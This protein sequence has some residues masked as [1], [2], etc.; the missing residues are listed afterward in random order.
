MSIHL[1]S[2]APV[3]TDPPLEYP[4]PCAERS[5]TADLDAAITDWVLYGIQPGPATRDL[6]AAAAG[7]TRAQKA[8]TALRASLGIPEIA[9]EGEAWGARRDW[10]EA[11][12]EAG[13]GSPTAAALAQGFAQAL[14][15]VPRPRE[16]SQARPGDLGKGLPRSP[17]VV[18][19]AIVDVAVPA[20]P[21]CG[22]SG[23]Q[24][25]PE[26]PRLH[27]GQISARRLLAAVTP[28]H[29]SAA[30]PP[31]ALDLDEGGNGSASPA[32]LEVVLAAAPGLEA[33]HAFVLDAIQ[34][35]AT[36]IYWA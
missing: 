16:P 31:D 5:A 2:N 15:A 1:Y 4:C 35:G 17:A 18:A 10:V 12:I 32:A 14:P 24:T 34:R 22:G 3:G 6:L 28:L 19:G 8:A 9:Y 36:L 20:C 30:L 27:G 26:R 29:A 11:S 33:E 21:G 23:I 7:R 25:T 13:R